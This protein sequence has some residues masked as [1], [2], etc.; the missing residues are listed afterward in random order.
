MQSENIFDLKCIDVLLMYWNDAAWEQGIAN[1]L[2]IK[3]IDTQSS[4]GE[5]NCT[6]N[7]R[8]NGLFGKAL[9]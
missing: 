1:M 4:S 9:L 7:Y 3:V 5:R 8:L 2:I 6:N